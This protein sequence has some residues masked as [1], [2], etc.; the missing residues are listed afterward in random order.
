MKLKLKEFMYDMVIALIIAISTFFILFLWKKSIL[1]SD[2]YNQGLDFLEFYKNHLSFTDGSWLYSWNIALGDSTYAQA[3]YYLLSPF[4]L[5]LLVLK[6]YSMVALLPY[7]MTMK[8]T[9]LAY[10]VSLYFRE[11]TKKEYRWIG[12]II[13]MACY[14]IVIYG[15]Y[16]VMWL[17]TFMFLPLVLLGI[18]RVIKNKGKKL[19]VVALFLFISSNYY[20]AAIMIPHIGIYGLI[21]Y[22]YIKGKGGIVKYII[23]MIGLAIVSLALSSFVLIPAIDIMAASAKYSNEVMNLSTS[24]KRVCEVLFK[25]FVGFTASPSNTYVTIIGIIVSISY[26]IFG[27]IKKV[28]LYLI[29]IG[30]MVFA[31]FNDRLNYLFNFGYS[32]AGGGYRYNVILNIYIG[33][34]VCMAIKEIIEEKNSK[35]KAAIVT[36]GFL[37]LIVLLSQF[38]NLGIRF[39]LVNIILIV[40]YIVILLL[41]NKNRKWLVVLLSILLLGE[42]TGYT[43]AIYSKR[44]MIPN[45]TR[46]EYT[47]LINYMKDNYGDKNRIEIKDT[48]SEANIYLAHN[49]E[50]VSGYSSL[51][52]G[53][54]ASIG[55]VLSNTSEYLVREEFRGRNIIAN[56]IGTKYYISKFNYCPYSNSKLINTF[57]DNSTYY[58]FEV[59][60]KYIK[61]F[62]NESLILGGLDKS[63]INKDAL[64]YSKLLIPTSEKVVNVE[65][66][67]GDII[68][69]IPIETSKISILESGEYYLVTPKDKKNIKSI[70]FSINGNRVER[71]LLLPYIQEGSMEKNEIYLGNFVSGDILELP[72]EL[73]NYGELVYIDGDYLDESIKK[74]NDLEIESLIRENGLLK[75]EVKTNK[76]GYVFFPIVYDK[77]WQITMDG[78]KINPTVVDG[79]FI[80]IEASIGSHII[81]MKYK[82][83]A[84]NLG[85]LLSISTLI[86]IVIANIKK[87]GYFIYNRKGKG[88]E[89]N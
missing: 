49:I 6:K 87:I 80:A 19:F 82:S 43:F 71:S 73:I 81:E 10:I 74:M 46:Y 16:Q 14:Y 79:G 78:E 41:L 89:K 9:I 29:P 52:N 7:F 28:R 1:I 57:E 40:A 12:T 64:L 61:H 35:L 47:R 44:N 34:I 38:K 13:Y 32:P 21:R 83:K 77:S 76:E 54:Y 48:V 17:D 24:Y 59:E 58:I 60:N 33:I 23:N 37:N 63:V 85:I 45:E 51:I 55:E 65:D 56:L 11:I 36:V 15:S 20:M 2:L 86:L 30:L 5:V 22:I 75:A 26:L 67:E 53:S 25:N 50:G 8:I 18:E 88:Y 84:I 39:L 27:N 3:L 4:N 62:D 42:L 70:D 72:E 66:F 31:I 68:K 69:N